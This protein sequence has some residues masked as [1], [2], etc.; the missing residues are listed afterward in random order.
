[1]SNLSVFSLLLIFA[2]SCYV[3]GGTEAANKSDDEFLQVSATDWYGCRQ[4]QFSLLRLAHTVDLKADLN[5]MLAGPFAKLFPEFPSFH[6]T[7]ISFVWDLQCCLTC[8]RNWAK[9]KDINTK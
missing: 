5:D 7:Q 2:T 9:F 3:S 1:M 6:W 4:F 8:T